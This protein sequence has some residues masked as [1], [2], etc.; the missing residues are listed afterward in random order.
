MPPLPPWALLPFPV[1][2]SK[3]KPNPPSPPWPPSPP[4]AWFREMMLFDRFIDPAALKIPPP[5]AGRTVAT[6]AAVEA[7]A[8]V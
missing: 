8:A 7:V 5:S 3:K 2:W 1:V 4:I 6:V